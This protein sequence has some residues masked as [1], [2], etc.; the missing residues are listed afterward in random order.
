MHL[1]HNAASWQHAV[2]IHRSG[3]I[4]RSKLVRREV[5]APQGTPVWESLSQITTPSQNVQ[6]ELPPSSLWC[7]AQQQHKSPVGE[8]GMSCPG[9]LCLTKAE[10]MSF[11]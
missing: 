5:S 3:L 2:F 6:R 11:W 1:L 4:G 9:G 10:T 7:L 8:Q